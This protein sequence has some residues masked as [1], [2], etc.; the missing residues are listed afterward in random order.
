MT[1]VVALNSIHKRPVC[2]VCEGTGFA[3]QI[4]V[5]DV[6]LGDLSV[7]GA[8][9]RVKWKQ[10]SIKLTKG[11]FSILQFLIERPDVIRTRD[12]LLNVLYGA[13]YAAYE[14]SVDSHVKRARHKFLA[15]DPEFDMIETE[16]GLGYR[17]RS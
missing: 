16:W 6:T 12:Q 17:W 14:R 9:R 8:T 1:K 5:Q 10:H 15:V 13:N 7:N 4:S 2:P 11:E 3:P